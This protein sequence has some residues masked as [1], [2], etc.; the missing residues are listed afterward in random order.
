MVLRKDKAEEWPNIA[1]D[2]G[3]TFCREIFP[4]IDAALCDISGLYLYLFHGK[5]VWDESHF[6]ALLRNC[7]RLRHTGRKYDRELAKYSK[8]FGF[9]LSDA[10]KNSRPDR[11]GP[12]TP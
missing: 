11:Q 9:E 2:V 8:A 10:G 3:G 1:R 4:K 5:N 7:A 12:W 6:E